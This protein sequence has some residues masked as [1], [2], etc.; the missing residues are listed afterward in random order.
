MKNADTANF[1]AH[2]DWVKDWGDVLQLSRNHNLFLFSYG[3]GQH[4]YFPTVESPNVWFVR[5]GQMFPADKQRVMSQLQNA[6]I[7]VEDL[8][9]ATSF[10]DY[11][12]EVQQYLSQMCLTDVTANFQ[13]W[14]KT[15]IP[16][17]NAV[18][19]QNPR[20]KYQE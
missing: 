18:C 15:S 19:R 4:H 10:I 13:I 11:D 14:R 12:P 3:T 6:E 5:T 1:Y 20:T 7:V 9:G 16:P 17:R 8:G 2:A